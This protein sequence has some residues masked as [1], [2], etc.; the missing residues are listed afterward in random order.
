MSREG[1]RNQRR[2]LEGLAGPEG[3]TLSYERLGSCCPYEGP[4]GPGL[5]DL[6]AVTW[7]G[8]SAKLYMSLYEEE[9]LF[10]PQGLTARE[11]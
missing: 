2:Y 7:E 6:Y 3:Q 10:V 9:E 4:N 8:G 5:L 1:S 11:P